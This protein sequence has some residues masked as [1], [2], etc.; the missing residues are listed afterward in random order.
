VIYYS[1]TGNNEFL[2]KEISSRLSCKSEAIIETSKRSFLT[3]LKEMILRKLP[4]IFEIKTDLDDFD[5]IVLVAPIWGGIA[6]TPLIA[7]IAKYSDTLRHYSFVSVCGGALGENK[8][9]ESYL[10]KKV[11]HKPFKVVQLYINNLLDRPKKY[12][13][14]YTSA[15]KIGPTDMNCFEAEIAELVDACK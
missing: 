10:T 12:K 15:Y 7:F 4:E 8:N 14:Q 11:G 1:K 2:A 3:L 9:I 5:H 6:A 13:A